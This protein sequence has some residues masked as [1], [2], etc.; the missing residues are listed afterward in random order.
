MEAVIQVT[1]RGALTIRAT[2]FQSE[3]QAQTTWLQIEKGAP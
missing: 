2:A 3:S 1:S